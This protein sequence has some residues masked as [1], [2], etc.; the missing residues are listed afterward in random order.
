MTT[1][2]IRK[3]VPEADEAIIEYI[4]GYLRENDFEDDED[5]IADFVK[6]I[7]IDAGGEEDK[8][9]EL[10]EHLSSLLQANK[11]SGAKKGL[12]KLERSVNMSQQNSL[13]ATVN[14]TR[15]S[16]DLEHVSGRRV[17]SQV[18]Q[19]KL[20]KAE[21]KIAAKMAKRQEKSNLKVEYEASRLLDE[22]KALQEQYKK[23]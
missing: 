8:I 2:L 16:A 9:D 18:N 15:G 4:D 21:A 7:L 14:L 5:A 11:N 6:P 20:R 22:Q 1:Q 13:S 17:Q 3:A 23:E 12:S 19:E 10:C